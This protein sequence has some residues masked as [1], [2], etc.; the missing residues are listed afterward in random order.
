MFAGGQGFVQVGYS[1]QARVE[2]RLTRLSFAVVVKMRT[3]IIAR[4]L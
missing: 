4:V 1:S 3:E 2:I